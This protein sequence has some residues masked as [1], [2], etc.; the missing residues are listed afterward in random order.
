[1]ISV[2]LADLNARSESTFVKRSER[3]NGKRALA[4]IGLRDG[5]VIET[6]AMGFRTD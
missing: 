5:D 4:T 3:K 2:E 1:M 6:R